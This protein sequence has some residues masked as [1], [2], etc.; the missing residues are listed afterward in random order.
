MMAVFVA[1]IVV[2]GLKLLNS[3]SFTI[4]VEGGES[5]LIP[6]S[7][8]YT[9]T[10]VMIVSVSSSLLGISLMYLL[11]PQQGEDQQLPQVNMLNMLL[12]DRKTKWRKIAVALKDDVQK[13]YETILDSDGII[14]QRELTEKTG[15]SKTKISRCLD[16][17]ELKDLIERKRRGMSNIVL[18]K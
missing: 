2:L 7:G 16:T 4:N 1:S 14:L 15:F 8:F 6:I 11:L 10:D 3:A 9:F 18:L 12:E 17:L 5:S 13:V